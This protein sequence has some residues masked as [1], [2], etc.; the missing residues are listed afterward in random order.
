MAPDVVMRDQLVR[1]IPLSKMLFS[2]EDTSALQVPATFCSPIAYWS[3]TPR[4]SLPAA[5]S[6]AWQTGHERRVCFGSP[7]SSRRA[8]CEEYQRPRH[9]A[10]RTCQLSA[11]PTARP[12]CFKPLH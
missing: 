7:N 10:Q 8:A 6:S 4:I 11:Q 3:A 1:S 12:A 5:R 9:G 2:H